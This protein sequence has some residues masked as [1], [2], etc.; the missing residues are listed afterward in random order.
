MVHLGPWKVYNYFWEGY[1]QPPK[2]NRPYMPLGGETARKIKCDQGRLNKIDRLFRMTADSD[3]Y[4]C[5]LF[6][7]FVKLKNKITKC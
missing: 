5:Q 3:R 2:R 6:C 1:H 7:L 4:C